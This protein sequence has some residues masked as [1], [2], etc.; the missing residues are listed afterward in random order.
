MNNGTSPITS[1]ISE[2]GCTVPTSW[3]AACTATA[4]TGAGAASSAAATASG[5]TRPSRSA[6][7]AEDVP[8]N[9]LGGV[10][11]RGVLD[12]RM[13]QQPTGPGPTGQQPQQPPMHRVGARGR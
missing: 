1:T 5:R 9:Q 12:G 11:H 8:E 4:A 7:I 6:G 2:T 3:F 13:Q 10:Q